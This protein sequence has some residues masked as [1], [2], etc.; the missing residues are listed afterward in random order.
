MK[1]VILCILLLI[2]VGC[3]K[4]DTM[5]KDIHTVI[6][7][8]KNILVGINYPITG[9]KTLDTLIQDEVE[10]IYNDFKEDYEN[11]SSIAQKSELNI[12][13]TYDMVN[14]EYI[15]I[16][17]HIFINSS[18]LAHPINELK[19]YVFDTKNKK[20][21]TLEDIISKT[22]MKQFAASVTSKLIEDYSSCILLDEVKN[23]ITASYQAYQLFTFDDTNLSIYFNPTVVTSSYCN[24]IEIQIPL[25][26]LNTKINIHKDT[27]SVN[28]QE[29]EL[30]K[31]IIDPNKKVIALTFDDGPS[32]YTK[33]IIEYLHKENAVGTFFI[34]GNKV[35]IYKDTINTCLQY[36]NEIG[37]HSYNHK[38][39]TKL[40]TDE[41]L[42]QIDKTQQIIYENTGYTPTI[43]RPTYGSINQKIRKNVTLDIVLWNV[44]TMDWKYKSVD[45]IVSRATKNVKDGDIILMHDTHERTYKAILKIVPELKKQGFTFVTV[46]ELKEINLLR[47]HKEIENE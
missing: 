9:F 26:I 23:K 21:L 17:I 12:D 47:Q 38:W 3:T 2:T 8:N 27:K 42:L 37:N 45:K 18:K 31:N 30:P 46:S 14:N 10:S 20:L 6:E 28:T 36:G 7:E 1:R 41:L 35:E 24:I 19:T 34:L 11:F 40:G 13:Y 32:R 29:I 44:D 33:K 4:K 16:C 5:Q 39:L 43:F 22:D 25:K 15:N